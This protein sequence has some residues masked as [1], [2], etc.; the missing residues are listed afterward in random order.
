LSVRDARLSFLGCCTIQ[1]YEHVFSGEAIAIGLPNRLFIVSA[2][3]RPRIAW[4]GKPDEAKLTELRQHIQVQ[5]AKLPIVLDATPEAKAE[6]EVW[7]K[8]L[9]SNEQAKRLDTIG[10]RLMPLLAFSCEKQTVDVEIVRDVIAILDYEMRLRAV[11]DPIDADNA[12]AK[13][14]ARIRRQLKNRGPLTERVLRKSTNAQRTG[15]WCFRTAL[16]N[17]EK[18]KDISLAAKKWRLNEE[19]DDPE[20]VSLGSAVI[21]AVSFVTAILRLCFQWVG[22]VPRSDI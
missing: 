3:A 19:D 9:P 7:Y 8:K 11:S 21:F 16:G 12:V 22:G 2:D 5:L 1:T 4:P 15:D 6:W 10:F 17:L 20:V 18:A 14:E 13:M